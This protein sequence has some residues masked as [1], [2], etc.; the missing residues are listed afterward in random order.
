M[1]DYVARLS[2][3][4][5]PV[6]R[7]D[8]DVYLIENRLIYVKEQCGPEDVDARFF[9]RLYPVDVNH[10]PAPSKQYGFHIR[11]FSFESRGWR[12]VETCF[13]K[14]HLPEYDI[15]A[16]ST[17]QYIPAEGRMWEGSFE[18]LEPADDGK[19]AP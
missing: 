18:V 17:G 6:I 14:T 5:P 13:A 3:D 2:G 12:E 15:A 8:W 10:L 9:L 16:V 7:S 19:T 11:N 1:G 4:N